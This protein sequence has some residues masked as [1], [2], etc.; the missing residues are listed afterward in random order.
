MVPVG[1]KREYKRLKRD[2][3]ESQFIKQ[4]SSETR[5]YELFSLG[6]TSLRHLETFLFEVKGGRGWDGPLLL[7]PRF[8]DQCRV[9]EGKR[10]THESA[11]WGGGAVKKKPAVLVRNADLGSLRNALYSIKH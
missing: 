9:A 4:T 6:R 11:G 1:W 8:L 2:G 3:V 5:T 7:W 10:D